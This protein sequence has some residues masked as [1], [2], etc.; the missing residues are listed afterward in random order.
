MIDRV[1]LY[2]NDGLVIEK[3]NPQRSNSIEIDLPI[4]YTR[5][6]GYLP[7]CTVPTEP[8]PIQP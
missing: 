6:N 1:V 7:Q 3:L 2:N 5:V 4:F 8:L